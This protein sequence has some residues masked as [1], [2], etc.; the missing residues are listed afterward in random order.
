MLAHCP[1]SNLSACVH[2]TPSMGIMTRNKEALGISVAFEIE[3]R[4]VVCPRSSEM[5]I[6]P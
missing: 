6:R 3:L 1:G 4:T 2:V 5:V